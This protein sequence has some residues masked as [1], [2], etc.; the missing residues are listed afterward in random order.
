M[1]EAE[2]RGMVI[3]PLCASPCWPT[4]ETHAIVENSEGQQ[5]AAHSDCAK[6]VDD[7]D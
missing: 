7:S 2:D 3:C 5:F 1:G 4:M 6:R